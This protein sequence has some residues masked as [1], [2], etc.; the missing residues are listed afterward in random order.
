MKLFLVVLLTICFTCLIGCN[1]VGQDEIYNNN[2]TNHE[3]IWETF[4]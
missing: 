4:D 3:Y 2:F 1:S